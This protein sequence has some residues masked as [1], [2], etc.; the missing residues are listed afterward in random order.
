MEGSQSEPEVIEYVF[1]ILSGPEAQVEADNAHFHMECDPS[2]CEI[3][4]ELNQQPVENCSLHLHLTGLEPD[5]YHLHVTAS[6]DGEELHDS[7]NWTVTAP[8]MEVPAQA[9]TTEFLSTPEDPTTQTTLSFSYECS[10]PPCTFDCQLA[11]LDR[12]TWNPCEDEIT[13]EDL[14][15]GHYLFRVRASNSVGTGPIATY[16]FEIIEAE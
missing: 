9:P 15:I 16:H 7:W 6:W 4:C 10:E 8:Q 11:P 14:T 1:Q 13:Y 3:L 2:G 12:N 5:D